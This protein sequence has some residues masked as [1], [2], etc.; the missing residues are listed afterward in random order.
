MARSNAR[1][2]RAGLAA[3]R[4]MQ[5]TPSMIVLGPRWE[6]RTGSQLT[7]EVD[8]ETLTRPESASRSRQLRSTTDERAG[9][10]G[11]FHGHL[12]H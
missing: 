2:A 6:T 3:E 10:Q 9:P 11:F 12:G 1:R 8:G 5:L 4:A 7:P